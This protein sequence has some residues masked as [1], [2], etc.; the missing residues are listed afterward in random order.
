MSKNLYHS[1]PD[2]QW[3]IWYKRVIEFDSDNL[4]DIPED[5]ELLSNNG[6]SL[7]WRGND[8]W[9]YKQSIPFLIENEYYFIDFMNEFHSEPSN[10]TKR[11]FPSNT[12]TYSFPY[13][14]SDCY[15]HGKYTIRMT[16]LGESEKLSSKELAF[17]HW[18]EILRLLQ[19]ANVRHGDLTK[20]NIIIRHDRVYILDW[21]ESR[22]IGDPRPTKRPESDYYWLEATFKD[23]YE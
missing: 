7:V 17:Y 21:A 14:I 1:R 12:F 16:D 2:I 19:K 6:I 15:K 4:M 20:P 8:G 22:F 5:S 11:L 10:S 23:L 9:I 3:P 18:N 13:V